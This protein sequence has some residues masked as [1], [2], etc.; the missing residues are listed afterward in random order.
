MIK[1]LITVE[2]EGLRLLEIQFK[3]IQAGSFSEVLGTIFAVGLLLAAA[4]MAV[5]DIDYFFRN[6]GWADLLASVPGQQMK[7]FRIFRI[8]KVVRLFRAFGVRRMLYEIRDNRAGSALYITVFLVIMVLEFG[9]ASM[10][11]IESPA[12]HAN[13]AGPADAVWWALVTIHV[14][15]DGGDSFEL[16]FVDRRNGIAR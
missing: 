11:Y 16:G 1:A 2:N 5:G 14:I 7:I 12:P 6:W 8:F 10:V 13:I 9:G 3:T 15:G 4:I